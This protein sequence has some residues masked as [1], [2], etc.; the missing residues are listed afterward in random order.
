MRVG[1]LENETHSRESHSFVPSLVGNIHVAGR[2]AF[3]KEPANYLL[4]LFPIPG[5]RWQ[6]ATATL[7]R[8]ENRE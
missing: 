6:L 4:R 1:C 2:S 5:H 7:V 8:P 3:G